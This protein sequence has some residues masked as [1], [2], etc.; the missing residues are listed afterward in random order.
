MPVHFNSFVGKDKDESKLLSSIVTK[1]IEKSDEVF[2]SREKQVFHATNYFIDEKTKEK[3]GKIV[4]TILGREK[5]NEIV[6]L[7]ITLLSENAV[8]LNFLEKLDK[9]SEANEYY[10]VSTID[11]ER[12][13]QIETVNRYSLE[14]SDIEN[15]KQTVY[16]SLFPFQLNLY[17]NIKE[18]DKEFGFAEPIKV[19]ETDMHVHGF[20]EDMVAVGGLLSGNL[21]EPSSFVIGKVKDFADVIAVMGEV[22]VSF[23]IIR[24]D[25]AMGE[26]PVAASRE[27]FDLKELAAGKTICILAD[28]K[29]DFKK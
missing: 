20:A 7:D 2:G 4:I 3:I 10:E 5:T 1:N 19:G 29:A 28:V 27:Q 24:V 16:L 13:F 15:T 26:I 14:Q 12:H 22:P 18:F 25:T 9:S 17:D 21:D 8:E 11:D 23:T 6:D